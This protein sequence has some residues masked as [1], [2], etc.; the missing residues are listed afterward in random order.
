VVLSRACPD[1]SALVDEILDTCRADC[2]AAL[3]RDA[4]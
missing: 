2:H 4:E 1:G 3:D